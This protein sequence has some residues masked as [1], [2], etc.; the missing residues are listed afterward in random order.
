MDILE[1]EPENGAR[2]RTNLH[3]ARELPVTT[4]P[5]VLDSTLP[6]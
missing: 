1:P 2:P 3:V 5:K 4:E 6:G